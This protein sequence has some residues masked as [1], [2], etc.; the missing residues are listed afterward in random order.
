M[1]ATDVAT[2]FLDIESAHQALHAPAGGL[3]TIKPRDLDRPIGDLR[4]TLDYHELEDGC[5]ARARD[6]VADR[7]AHDEPATGA[8]TSPG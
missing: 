8:S 7:A 2:L 3:F 1:A 4:H 5:Q 6:A